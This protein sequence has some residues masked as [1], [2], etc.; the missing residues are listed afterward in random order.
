MARAVN[1]RRRKA[2]SVNGLIFSVLYVSLLQYFKKC[3]YILTYIVIGQRFSLPFSM[4]TTKL[5]VLCLARWQ[6]GGHVCFAWQDGSLVVMLQ[7]FTFYYF[8]T[9]EVLTSFN[10]FISRRITTKQCWKRTT[11][12]KQQCACVC[13]LS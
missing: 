2:L 1:G 12:C 9:V 5:C 7:H 11:N 3:T 4:L 13:G 6:L 10:Q 8:L